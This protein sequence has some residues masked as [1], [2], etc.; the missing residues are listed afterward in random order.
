VK[1]TGKPAVQTLD[2]GGGKKVK[3]K[4]LEPAQ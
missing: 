4:N 1:K 3:A 2:I